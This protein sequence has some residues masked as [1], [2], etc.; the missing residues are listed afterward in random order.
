MAANDH[1]PTHEPAHHGP[2][3]TAGPERA[4]WPRQVANPQ[5]RL[6]S[7]LVRDYAGFTE[8]TVPRRLVLPATASVPLVVKLADSPY[9]PP[10][11]VMGAHDASTVLKGT[12]AR[13]YL[14]VILNPL[15]AYTVLGVPL[16]QL[17]GHTVDLI[18][19]LGPGGRRLGERLRESRSW[20]RR[21][22][23]VDRFLLGRLED[24]PRPAPE[25]VW[26]WRRLVATGGGVPIGRL[27]AE[28]GWSHKHLITRFRQQ[29]GLQP[30]LA[31][32]LARLDRVWRRL[33]QGGE[34]DW[35][36]VAV[37]A[38]YA[39]QAHLVRDFGRFTGMTPTQFQAR[40]RS[41]REVKSVQDAVA[42]SA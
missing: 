29:V 6:R 7:V 8:A 24:G 26:V 20:R 39:D 25:V 42:A 14:E 34:L 4:R 9:R 40:L 16:D 18:D 31:A 23:L 5:P 28:V 32:R 10:A 12:C 15:G 22:G 30:K 11:F 3:T 27:A 1:H 17:A 13:S 19:L 35:G 2:A 37:E 38:G 36:L 33:D 21:F 41:G